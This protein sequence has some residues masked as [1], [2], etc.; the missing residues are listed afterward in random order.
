M[1]NE[2]TINIDDPQ[3]ESLE[4]RALKI[5]AD[6]TEQVGGEEDMELVECEGELD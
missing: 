5:R 6:Q 1:A 3:H 4:E 2:L